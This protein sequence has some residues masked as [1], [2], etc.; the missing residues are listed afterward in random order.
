MHLHKIKPGILAHQHVQSLY[1]CNN[2]VIPPTNLQVHNSC[3]LLKNC[4]MRYEK[5]THEMIFQV[6]SRPQLNKYFWASECPTAQD[7]VYR[8]LTKYT[9][10]CSDFI[11]KTVHFW[12]VQLLNILKSTLRSTSSTVFQLT[13]FSSTTFGVQGSCLLECT[14]KERQQEKRSI[15]ADIDSVALDQSCS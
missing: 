9:V 5:M 6:N 4:E 12:N 14:K 3:T 15:T 10:Y 2:I 11:V 7:F 13:H 1:I 8:Y